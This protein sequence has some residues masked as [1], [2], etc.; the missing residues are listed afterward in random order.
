MGKCSALA[1]VLQLN[2]NLPGLRAVERP[3]L[4]YG[5]RLNAATQVSERFR[6]TKSLMCAPHLK[7]SLRN[8]TVLI[9]L[10][11][12]SSW[13]FFGILNG[14]WWR[15]RGWL[16]PTHHMVSYNRALTTQMRVDQ[17]ACRACTAFLKPKKRYFFAF[18]NRWEGGSKPSLSLSRNRAEASLA[19]PGSHM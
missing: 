1:L 10:K 11:W 17:E 3:L 6:F 7:Y 13:R 19:T 9:N 8:V 18:K 5:T 12:A 14:S 15:G 2:P 4:T 16:I